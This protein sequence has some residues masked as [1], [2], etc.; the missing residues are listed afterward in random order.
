MLQGSKLN[1]LAD[2]PKFNTYK[3][4]K[5]I[6][7]F[8]CVLSVR[9]FFELSSFLLAKNLTDFGKKKLSPDC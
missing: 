8:I 4:N 7:R 1:P 9:F 6:D 5:T 3:V 2:G